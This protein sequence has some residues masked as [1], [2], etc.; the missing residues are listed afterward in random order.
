MTITCKKH[1]TYKA[2][3]SP[4]ADC[5]VCRKIF[6]EAEIERNKETEED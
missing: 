2:L 4:S 1:P 5:E 3:R 6:E